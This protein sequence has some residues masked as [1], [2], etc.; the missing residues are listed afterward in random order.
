MAVIMKVIENLFDDDKR[1]FTLVGI[2]IV[3]IVF[4]T[5]I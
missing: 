5:M 4:S 2:L 3:E 1:L